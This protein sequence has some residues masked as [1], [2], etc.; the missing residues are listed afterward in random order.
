[1]IAPAICVSI[2]VSN[3]AGTVG[4]SYN[5]GRSDSVD[6][7]S[8]LGTY[9]ISS[10]WSA[11]Y[12]GNMQAIDRWYYSKDGKYSIRNRASGYGYPIE[13]S[14]Y[15]IQDTSSIEVSNRFYLTGAGTSKP[16]YLNAILDAY[17]PGSRT[18]A[19]KFQGCANLILTQTTGKATIKNYAHA[20][21][22][23]TV[24][25][26][27]SNVYLTEDISNAN[28]K[29]DAGIY[30]QTLADRDFAWAHLSANGASA[31]FSSLSAKGSES[32]ATEW[33]VGGTHRHDASAKITG[34]ANIASIESDAYYNRNEYTNGYRTISHGEWQTAPALSSSTLTAS[35]TSRNV[36][37]TYTNVQ[38]NV[39]VNADSDK[40]LAW[41][42][43]M[44]GHV[45]AWSALNDNYLKSGQKVNAIERTTAGDISKMRIS[46]GSDIKGTVC[47]SSASTDVTAKAVD[48]NGWKWNGSTKSWS[49]LINQYG[50][51]NYYTSSTSYYVRW[52]FDGNGK[53]L[54]IPGDLNG[55]GTITYQELLQ[56][57][58]IYGK[59]EVTKLYVQNIGKAP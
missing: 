47:Q 11:K 55:D 50:M 3:D 35:A 10:T 1:M 49:K 25:P 30:S 21:K 15:S 2:S 42:K 34:K 43:S 40:A 32:Y 4:G 16:G 37:S 7:T 45:S 20:W 41:T 39:V 58:D 22:D 28:G 38:S 57:S 56:I 6:E 14:G 44:S 52:I 36:K 53:L 54:T 29:L 8:S 9:S 5:L 27:V 31:L 59:G 13:F 19:D 51:S 26:S 33:R 48:V 12:Y 17:A 24:S 46:V 18:T 23:L